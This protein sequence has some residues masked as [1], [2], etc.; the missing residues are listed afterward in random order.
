M[1]IF[2]ALTL[3]LPVVAMS[4]A[5][6][7]E[8]KRNC[9]AFKAAPGVKPFFSCA[10]DFFTLEPIHPIVR[11]IVPGGGVGIGVN[12]TL[13]SPKGEW[14]RIFTVNGAISPRA[15]WIT[16]TKFTLRHPKFGENNTAGPGDAFAAHFYL[17]ARG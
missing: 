14:H 4:A 6:I 9:S 10:S 5:S 8:F 1:K 17:R 16:E 11:S 7:D 13:D 12:Y 15:F 2:R 3:L